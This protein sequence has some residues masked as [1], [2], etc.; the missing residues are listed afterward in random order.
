MLLRWSSPK[1][2][3]TH[4]R[5]LPAMGGAE[6]ENAIREHLCIHHLKVAHE[7]KEAEYNL[8]LTYHVRSDRGWM[9]DIREDAEEDSERGHQMTLLRRLCL[10]MM[11]FPLLT[12]LQRTE[13]HQEII[14]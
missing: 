7:T 3:K 1:C 11:S 13:R 14:Q 4:A 2:R 9:V 10:P 6:E 5:D 12:I 8:R